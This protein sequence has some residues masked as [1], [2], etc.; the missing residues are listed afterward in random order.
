MTDTI[1]EAIPLGGLGEFGMNMMAYRHGQ[2]TI[3][4]DAGFG[5]PED[6]ILG[7]DVVIPDISFLLQAPNGLSAIFL[8]HAHEDHIGALP[9]ILPQ[10]P[11]VPVFGSRLTIGLV[12]EK[13]AEY[14]I[15]DVNFTIIE[16]RQAIENGPFRVE[17]LHVTHSMPACM[18]LAITTPIGTI[19]HSGDFKFDQSPMDGRKSDLARLSEYG[20]RGVVALFSDSTNADRPGLST[21]ERTVR[22]ALETIL[23]GAQHK[24]VIAA[25]SSSFH[26]IQLVTDLAQQFG[27]K[28]VPIGRSMIGNMAVAQELGYLRIPPG[29]VV[30]A[31]EARQLPDSQVLILAAGTQGEPMSALSRLAVDEFKGVKVSQHD[32]VIL[33]ARRIPG[34]ERRIANVMNH[35]SRRGAR[36]IDDSSAGVHVSGHGSREDLKLM[37]T[38]TRPRFFIP[39]HGEYRQL[40]AHA[41]LAMETGIPEADIL[42]IE[43]GIP[44]QITAT[45]IARGERVPT[46]RRFIDQ[47]LVGEVHDVILKDRKY[48]SEDGFVVALLPLGRGTGRLE[49]TPQIITR[50][51]VHIDQSDKF[52]QQTQDLLVELVARTPAEEKRD[53]VLFKEIVRKALKKF[54]QKQTQKRPVILPVI[55][56]I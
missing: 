54:F 37:I 55:V 35:F 56:E 42:L 8:T 43:D 1:L 46:G 32:T 11:R 28:V 49:G 22:P 52:L 53:E 25:F 14:N 44:A 31:T 29:L 41:D 40:R 10:L 38:L 20:E 4:V 48:L 33:S 19:I 24:V 7:V 50:G 16:P 45:S 2:H 47:D 27:R 15:P 30:P 51:F 6:D 36:V 5:F 18:A 34:N 12:R 26:R 9:H 39:I 23:L 3:L 21:S 17:F 13:L